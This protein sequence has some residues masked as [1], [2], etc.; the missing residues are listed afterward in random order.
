LV[1]NPKVA[2]GLMH[3]ASKGSVKKQR[4]WGRVV[5]LWARL[6]GAIV[7]SILYL[8]LREFVTFKGMYRSYDLLTAAVIGSLMGAALSGVAERKRPARRLRWARLSPALLLPIVLLVWID[9]KLG[10]GLSVRLV[11]ISAVSAYEVGAPGATAVQ[12]MV[13]LFLPLAAALLHAHLFLGNSIT[14]ATFESIA[15]G[16]TSA[17]FVLG[18]AFLGA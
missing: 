18:A 8:V 3:R 2:D 13:F 7:A 9:R 1:S 5:E 12:R 15:A 6:M 17:L 16:V 4:V 10:L 11:A 14:T